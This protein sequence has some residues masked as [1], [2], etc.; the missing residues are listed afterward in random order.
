MPWINE[1]VLSTVANRKTK[2][3]YPNDPF[4]TFLGR[5]DFLL[6]IS[7]T[8]DSIPCFLRFSA[9]FLRPIT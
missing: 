7:L 8:A 9:G 1:V 5:S 4:V 6:P 2:S 3:A